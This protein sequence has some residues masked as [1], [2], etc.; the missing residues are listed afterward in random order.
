MFQNNSRTKNFFIIS[1]SFLTLIIAACKPFTEPQ[2]QLRIGTNVWSGY[3]PLYLAR[4]LGY[5]DESQL[6]LVEFNSTS[7][8][9]T[10]LR[11][12]S[13][14]AA[15]LTLDEAMTLLQDGFNLKII[16]VMDFSDGGD[17]LLGKPYLKS[18]EM[19]QNK[20]IAVENTAVG[21]ILLDGALQAANLDVA[22]IN[23]IS[24]TWNEHKTCFQKADAVVTFEPVKTQLLKQGAIQ[25]FDSSQI[26]DRI[27][28]VLVVLEDI[29]AE[30]QMS[31][32]QLLQGYFKARQYFFE[33]RQK[34]AELI[35]PR[36]ALTA[37]EVIK[38]FEGITLPD[39]EENHALLSSESPGIQKITTRLKDLMLQQN[40]LSKD[41][42][43]SEI[44]N[45][46]LLPVLLQ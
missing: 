32:R 33:N 27:V 20:T 2:S 6:R 1:F 12:G 37:E 31:L 42:N 34:A 38:A 3:E 29:M 23:I 30:D 9:I 18:L 14:E 40:L 44:A 43:V 24:C 25:L 8:V 4:E 39:L 7:D 5:Y 22:E 36:M 35:A 46:S 26:P 16:L 21:A 13:L 19:L 28:D 11:N 10:A 15:A 45:G 41:V 17:A